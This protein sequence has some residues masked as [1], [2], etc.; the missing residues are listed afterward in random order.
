MR[1]LLCRE[2]EAQGCRSERCA[3]VLCWGLS[4]SEPVPSQNCVLDLLELLFRCQHLLLAPLHACAKWLWSC[5]R[6][7]SRVGIRV[8]FGWLVCLP[9]LDA[10]AFF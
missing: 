10:L 9:F 8:A 4:P 5:P 2:H 7:L 1:A 3:G 6:G